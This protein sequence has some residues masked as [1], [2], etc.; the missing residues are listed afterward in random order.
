[1]TLE[2]ASCQVVHFNRSQELSSTRK[3]VWII[4]YQEALK[5]TLG[6]LCEAILARAPCRWWEGMCWSLRCGH[7]QCCAGEEGHPALGGGAP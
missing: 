2:L 5:R 7:P 3:V 1:M 4:R 6:S